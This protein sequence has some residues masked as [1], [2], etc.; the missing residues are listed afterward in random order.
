MVIVET[1]DHRNAGWAKDTSNFGHRM[2]SKMGWKQG[3]G[4]GKDRTGSS[5]HLRGVRRADET[6]GLGATTDAHGGDGWSRTNEGFRGVLQNLREQHGTTTTTG[7]NDDD[8]PETSRSESRKKSKRTK[9]LTLARN[10]VSAGHA[11]KMREAKNLST[12]SRE[13]V[14]AIFGVVPQGCD[15]FGAIAAAA[16]GSSSSSATAA[17]RRPDGDEP[18]TRNP[19][20]TNVEERHDEKKKKKKDKKKRKRDDEKEKVHKKKRK[21]K[22]KIKE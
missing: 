2:L 20:T 13:D 16:T 22:K 4:L 10:R 17:P 12:K 19:E 18:K 1:E 15:P 21:S 11:R 3:Q 6:L 7:G 5:T 14:A 8:E 9:S